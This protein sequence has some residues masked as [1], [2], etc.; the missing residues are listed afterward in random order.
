MAFTEDMDAFFNTDDFAVAAT[1]NPKGTGGGAATVHVIFDRDYIEANVGSAGIE[2]DQPL[3]LG[4]AAD[5]PNVKQ[6]DSLYHPDLGINYEIVNPRPDGTGMIL[7]QL[8]EP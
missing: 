1:Y 7:L 5:F 8:K 3:A 4:K 2:G 6:G